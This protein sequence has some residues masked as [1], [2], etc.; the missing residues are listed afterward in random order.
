MS[1]VR[2]HIPKSSRRGVRTNGFLPGPDSDF[3]FRGWY[4]SAYPERSDGDPARPPP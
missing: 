2:G 3:L 1:V 4:A